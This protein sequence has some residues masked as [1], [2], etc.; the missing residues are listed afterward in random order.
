EGLLGAG[1]TQECQYIQA[2]RLVGEWDLA[3]VRRARRSET[4]FAALGS[5]LWAMWLL[6]SLMTG[7]SRPGAGNYSCSWDM[8]T[9]SRRRPQAPRHALVRIPHL[10][11]R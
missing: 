2:A 5:G 7:S 1:I 11:R 4:A 3:E 9:A 10:R 8:S 6:P